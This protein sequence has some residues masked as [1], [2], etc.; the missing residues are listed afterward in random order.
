MASPFLSVGEL[1]QMLKVSEK[2]IYQQLGKG[3]I[4]GAFKISGMWFIDRELFLS[5]LR[6]KALNR[7]K[8]LRQ[9]GSKNRHGL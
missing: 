5:A 3:E 2:W 6:E 8:G 4:P 1:S 7:S 9:A